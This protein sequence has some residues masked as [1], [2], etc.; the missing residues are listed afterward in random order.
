MNLYVKYFSQ[1]PSHGTITVISSDNKI[2]SQQILYVITLLF[3]GVGK[4]NVPIV[5][6]NPNISKDLLDEELV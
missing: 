3:L 6:V 4:Y 1:V 5:Q 2:M